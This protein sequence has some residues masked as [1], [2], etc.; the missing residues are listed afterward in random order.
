MQHNILV[1]LD[2]VQI[3]SMIHADRDRLSP[4]FP[5]YWRCKSKDYNRS[6]CYLFIGQSR[7]RLS[8]G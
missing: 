2:D 7:A 6:C 8:A 4:I 5:C 1:G 3:F